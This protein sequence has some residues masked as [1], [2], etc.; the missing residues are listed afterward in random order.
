M[1]TIQEAWLLTSGN[2]GQ[3]RPGHKSS[4]P[5]VLCY[6]LTTPEQDHA[7]ENVATVQPRMLDAKVIDKELAIDPTIKEL[8][9]LV[10]GG[11]NKDA[12]D[13]PQGLRL[14]RETHLLHSSR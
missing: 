1:G 4:S 10:E 7:K 14:L 8:K 11:A 9:Q 2:H 13:W 12:G 3:C 5:G 6:A